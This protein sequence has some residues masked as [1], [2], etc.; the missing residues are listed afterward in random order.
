MPFYALLWILP[1]ALLAVAALALFNLVLCRILEA[2]VPPAGRFVEI[3]GLRLHIVDSGEKPGQAQPPILFIHGLLGQLSNFS[4]AVAGFF[5]ERRTVLIDRPGS[6]YSPAAASQSLKAQGDLVA[7]IIDELKLDKPLI[8]GHS[9]GGAIALALALDHPASVGGLALIAPLTHPVTAP[10]KAFAKLPPPRRWMLWLGAWTF[11][12]IMMLLAFIPVRRQ[13]FAPEP[14]AGD[15]WN[16]GGGILSSRPSAML[17]A[18]RDMEHQPQELPR[19]VARY[20]SLAMPIG[21][22]F[23]AGDRLLD[24][25]AQ[26]EVF[27]AKNPNAEMTLIDGGHMLPVTQP[28]ATEAFIRKTLARMVAARSISQGELHVHG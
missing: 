24:A 2:L 8:V 7:R 26:G 28:R 10:P 18:A 19:L 25:K 20:P 5:P 14:L 17:A 11:G 16:R 4:Y 6:G 3:D 22:L 15:Y 23:G 12:P 1:L 27:C 9:L 13:V 21:V